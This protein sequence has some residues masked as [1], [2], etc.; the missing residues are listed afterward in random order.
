MVQEH[1]L[2]L[3]L[4]RVILFEI[5]CVS[6]SSIIILHSHGSFLLSIPTVGNLAFDL[7]EQDVIDYF[8]K[9]GPVKSVRS[10]KTIFNQRMLTFSQS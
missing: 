9:V 10:V 4:V 5:S 1:R 6:Y 3:C 8:S 2:H 7:S